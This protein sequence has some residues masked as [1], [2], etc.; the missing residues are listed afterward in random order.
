MTREYV[1]SGLS[2]ETS[3]AAALFITVRQDESGD[4]DPGNHRR[5]SEPW[6]CKDKPTAPL[7]AC[8]LLI[9]G[10]EGACRTR[11]V[12]GQKIRQPLEKAPKKSALRGVG[13]LDLTN[14]VVTAGETKKSTRITT[15]AGRGNRQKRLLMEDSIAA[16]F[17]LR[18]RGRGPLRYRSPDHRPSV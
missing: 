11:R 4:A 12:G 3:P 16:P 6:T 10:E 18:S 17:P 15:F 2:S 5:H 14:Q 13:R 9:H 7:A 1:R 8:T